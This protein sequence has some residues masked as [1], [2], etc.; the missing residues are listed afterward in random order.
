MEAPPETST[1]TTRTPADS[2]MTAAAA[3]GCQFFGSF[4]VCPPLL[5]KYLQAR[6]QGAVGNP[7]SA[8]RCGLVN[9]GCG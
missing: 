6:T 7:V 5:D 3:T 9:Q 2:A 8:M 1:Q 4:S